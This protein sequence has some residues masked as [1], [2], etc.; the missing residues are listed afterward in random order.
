[1]AVASPML[2]FMTT[3]SIGEK[4]QLTVPKEF[5]DELRL[6]PGAPVAILRMGNGLLLLPEQEHFERLCERVSAALLSAGVTVESA[7]ESLPEI[8]KQIYEEHY[9]K[10]PVKKKPI[11]TSKRHTT[12]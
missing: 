10:I 4:G 8:R 7:V 11:R 3:T 2:E 5:R 6:K 12:K 1:M 9:G